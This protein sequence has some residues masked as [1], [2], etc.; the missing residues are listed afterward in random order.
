M[1]IEITDKEL[2]TINED[3]RKIAMAFMEIYLVVDGIRQGY[4]GGKGEGK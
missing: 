4:Y 3:L 1:K 2:E